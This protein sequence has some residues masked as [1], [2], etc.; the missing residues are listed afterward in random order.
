[1][2][3]TDSNRLQAA[4]GKPS[5]RLSALANW[6]EAGYPGGGGTDGDR[7]QEAR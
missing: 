1:M 2:S 7:A 4:A 5:A 6:S 3:E